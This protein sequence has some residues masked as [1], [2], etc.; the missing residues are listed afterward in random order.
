M[1]CVVVHLY[2]R[3]RNRQSCDNHRG[4]SLLSIAGKALARVLLNRLIEHLEGGLLPESQCGFRK[5]R[6]TIDMVF[7]ARQLQERCQEQNVGLYST[8]VN[9]T[10]AFN[11]VSREGLWKIMAKYGRPQKF[12]A[13]VRQ[14]HDGMMAR[15]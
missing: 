5:E 3:K 1:C 10:K 14:F 2:K 9:L 12:I 4:I 6:G 7:A 13:I 11:T 15:V 8:F